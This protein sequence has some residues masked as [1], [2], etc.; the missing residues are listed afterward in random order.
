MRVRPPWGSHF[1]SLYDI[2]LKNAD[3]LSYQDVPSFLQRYQARA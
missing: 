3:V 2:A 1:A